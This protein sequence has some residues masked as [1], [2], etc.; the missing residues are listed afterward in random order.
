MKN[1]FNFSI[2][3][4]GVLSAAAL[5]CGYSTF[6]SFA[7]YIKTLPYRRV[8]NDNNPLAVL[9]EQCGTCSAKHKLLAALAHE[10]G[11][12]EVNLTVGI[13]WMSEQNTPGVNAAL[14]GTGIHAVPEAHCYLTING[15]RHDFTGLNQGTSSPFDALLSEHQVLPKKLSLM[16]TDLHKQEIATW[17]KKIGLSPNEGWAVRE[18]CIAALAA[19]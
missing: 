12:F 5:H 9:D 10:C 19:R 6:L 17:S 4:S 14:Q 18:A 8:S 16:K 11:H 2:L 15:I 13:Y 3:P 7:N 1:E